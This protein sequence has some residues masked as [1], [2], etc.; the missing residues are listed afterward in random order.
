[1]ETKQWLD[2]KKA[3]S[4]YGP[5]VIG[6][7]IMIA[8]SAIQVRSI[9]FASSMKIPFVQEA[10]TALYGKE[11]WGIWYGKIG[12]W[13]GCLVLLPFSLMNSMVSLVIT[14]KTCLSNI[15]A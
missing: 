15:Y 6:E 11:E 12:L 14:E 3:F 7:T 4:V 10:V 13:Y 8:S 5:G 1:M 2:H 9:L